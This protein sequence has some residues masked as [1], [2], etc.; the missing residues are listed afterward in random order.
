MKTD[1]EAVWGPTL[2]LTEG[3]VLWPAAPLK[4]LSDGRPLIAITAGYENPLDDDILWLDY[5]RSLFM[6]KVPVKTPD[7]HEDWFPTNSYNIMGLSARFEWDINVHG[8]LF[9]AVRGSHKA[10]NEG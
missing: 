9:H 4:N 7:G 3:V 10:R 5:D 8:I 2:E 1:K 6:D